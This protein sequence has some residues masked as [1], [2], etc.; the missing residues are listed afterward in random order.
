MGLRVPTHL[1][2]SA[3]KKD[4][5]RVEKSHIMS[6]AN[7]GPFLLSGMT[8]QTNA[9]SQK[10]TR[11]KT[12]SITLN[13]NKILLFAGAAAVVA[14][15]LIYALRTNSSPA[16]GEVQGT[17]GKPVGQVDQLNPFNNVAAIPATVD[18]STIRF[19]K[20]RTVDLASKTQTT[21]YPELCKDRQFRESDSACQTVKVLEKVQAIEARYSYAGPAMSAG[22]SVPGRDSFSVY[23]HP[24]DLASA[25]PVEKLNREQAE[26][27]F[28]VS[29]TRP[30]VQKRVVD[31]D[32]S[33]YC[34]GNYVDGNWVRKDANCKDDVQYISQS[35]PSTNL[36]V[37]VDVHHTAAH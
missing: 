36:L 2:F 6:D 24:E 28:D 18:P 7:R 27:L 4:I 12:R 22:E 10:R 5:K 29:T 9:S 35:A 15:G 19:E 34:D 25:G 32:H 17:M 8:K 20:L 14:I 37:Q 26:S 3:L 30:T 13:T 16:T 11:S 33:K 21:A 31:K 23:F 1:K